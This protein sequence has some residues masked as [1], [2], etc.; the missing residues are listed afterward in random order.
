M[1]Q[2]ILDVVP[3]P[4]PTLT[5]FIPGHN[6]ELLTMLD[7]LVHGQENE[8]F[9]YLWGY[10]GCGKTHLLKAVSEDGVRNGLTTVYL[11]CKPDTIFDISPET[12]GCIVLDNVDC[13]GPA[14]QI[15]LFNLYNHIRDESRSWL[16]VS[17]LVPPPQLALRADLVTRLGWGLVYRVHELTDEEKTDVMKN[18]AT[19]RGFDLPREV[20]NYLL[21]YGHRDLPSLLAMIDA[22]DEYALANQRQ[23]TLPLLR[24]LL[25]RTAS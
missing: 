4:P 23:V 2:L 10:A 22:L 21:H 15:S 19:R 3:S 18:H 9:I 7:R 14:A 8:R 13:L 25:T 11:S 20:C 17:G 6:T 5:G 16:L 12:A 1:K 24:E